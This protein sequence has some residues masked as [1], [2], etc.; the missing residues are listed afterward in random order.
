MQRVTAAKGDES[1]AR[2][3]PGSL[4]VEVIFR[5]RSELQDGN[6]RRLSVGRAPPAKE[7]Q[8]KGPAVGTSVACWRSR[9]KGSVAHGQW[10]K[11][12]VKREGWKE[13]HG[14]ILRPEEGSQPGD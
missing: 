4:S 13:N 6:T 14:Q 12:A 2:G 10:A 9:R 7:S 3:H 1:R 8:C 11:R 5:L